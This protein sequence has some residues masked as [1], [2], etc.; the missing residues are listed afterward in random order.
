MTPPVDAEA[1]SAA[2]LLAM[3]VNVI[4]IL[5]ALGVLAVWLRKRVK[6]AF[7]NATSQ[8]TAQLARADDEL[9]EQVNDLNGLLQTLTDETRR[10]HERLDRHLETHGY[11]SPAVH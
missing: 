1:F 4:A 2:T 9:K 7:N 11:T 3:V 6:L 10:A 5:S 8:L